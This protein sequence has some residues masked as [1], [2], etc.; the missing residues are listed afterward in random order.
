M[1]SDDTLPAKS[2]RTLREALRA[3]LP[4]RVLGFVMQVQ[5]PGLERDDTTAVDHVK[6]FR[7]RPDLRFEGRIHEQVL[8]SIRRLGGDVTWIGAYVVHDG[9]DRSPE[10]LARKLKRDL[11]LLELDALDRPRHPFVLFNLGMTL[12]HAGDYAQAETALTD[13]IGVSQ[14]SESHLRKAYALLVDALTGQAKDDEARR[15]CWEGLGRFPA[16]PELLFKSGN[17]A[18][19]REEWTEAAP[20]FES[21]L[22]Q[23][24]PR[25]FSS[26]DVGILGWRS[27]IGLAAAYEG[28]G[29]A[30]AAESLW[31][32]ALGDPAARHH[33]L[34]GFTCFLFGQQRLAE[35]EPLLRELIEIDP[36][37][38]A[39][40]HNLG[41]SL[42]QQGRARDAATCFETSLALRPAHPPTLRLLLLAARGAGER[43]AQALSTAVDR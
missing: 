39:A 31:R 42:L 26:L 35:A 38:A 32:E 15:R 4:D 12:N 14:H 13:C 19:R 11:R 41:Q 43:G 27:R 23:P 1:D 37:N 16:D 24:R 3:E 6:L 8:P 40:H 21:I 2:G 18:L 10:G 33:A 7:N 29:R 9:A 34:E 36:R 28:L 25:Y 30:A 5:C 20:A 17:M 22:S